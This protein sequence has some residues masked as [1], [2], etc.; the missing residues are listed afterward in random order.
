MPSR[1]SRSP[2]DKVSETDFDGQSNF[3]TC[4]V[5]TL[6]EIV[7]ANGSKSMRSGRHK[8][9]VILQS[10]LREKHEGSLTYQSSKVHMNILATL[11]PAEGNIGDR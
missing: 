11:R 1:Q 8:M 5:H 9:G 4:T 6:E 2:A 10:S 7:R 3:G